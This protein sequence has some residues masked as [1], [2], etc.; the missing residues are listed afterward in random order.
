MADRCADCG[1]VYDLSQSAGV[2]RAI[3]ER[4]AE[5]AAILRGREADLRSRRRPAVWS[6]LEY[7]CHL[8]DMLLVQRERVLAARRIDGPDCLPS[9]RDERVVHDGY[10]EQ[11]PEDVARQLADAAQ[12]FANVL[13]RLGPDDWDRSVVYHYPETRER[14][15]RWV[16]LHTMHEAQHH[17]LDIRRQL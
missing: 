10:A 7:A 15:L 16:A 11:E 8:R 13:A 1:F 3:P 5:V 14:S 12:L 9:G 2:A 6:P 4:V 17:L